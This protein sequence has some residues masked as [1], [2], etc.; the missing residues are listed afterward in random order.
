M[1]E[2][3]EALLQR[4]ADAATS[5]DLRGAVMLLFHAAGAFDKLAGGMPNEDVA[6]GALGAA[7]SAAGASE[8][9][10]TTT[11]ETG[12]RHAE[13]CLCLCPR[14]ALRERAALCRQ[15]AAQ[16]Q[17]TVATAAAATVAV[18][19]AAPAASDGAF[20]V[21]PAAAPAACVSAVA[22]PAA[23]TAAY[24]AVAV[25]PVVAL[26]VPIAAIAAA[27]LPTASV[28]TNA[29]TDDRPSPVFTLAAVGAL[30]AFC[31]A[32]PVTAVVA[33]A[34][35]MAATCRDDRLG[36]AARAAG[37]TAA[38]AVAAARAFNRTH[39]LSDKA[40]ALSIKARERAVEVEDK[41][42][43]SHPY[44]AAALGTAGRLGGYAVC[45]TTLGVAAST[46]QA[47][48]GRGKAAADNAARLTAAAGAAT[49]TAM[50]AAAC[51]DSVNAAANAAKDGARRLVGA[52]APAAE[53]PASG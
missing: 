40:E 2:Q 28:A 4:A 36:A 34:A 25:A 20:V 51:V 47:L 38:D 15:H 22:E 14:A 43:E 5:G 26:P 6:Q 13:V 18:A 52:A 16:L 24:Q 50:R 3:A 33:A 44:A 41:L 23:R 21:M 46:A 12:L 37:E 48:V 29:H 1:S 27:P 30:A 9:A 53:A 39:G 17:A 7:V 10:A 45:S 31:A 35:T 19:P 32:G 49:D 11:E 42:K 8:A